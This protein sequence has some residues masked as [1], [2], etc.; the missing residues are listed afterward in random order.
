MRFTRLLY[1]QNLNPDCTQTRLFP[2][3]YGRLAG[4]GDV[5]GLPGWGVRAVGRVEALPDVFCRSF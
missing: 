1:H 3:C 5:P 4:A 2:E